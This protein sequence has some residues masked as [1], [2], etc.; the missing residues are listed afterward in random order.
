MRALERVLHLPGVNHIGAQTLAVDGELEVPADDKIAKRVDLAVNIQ[1]AGS[2]AALKRETSERR[3]EF[4]AEATRPMWT[5]IAAQN[6]N[7]CLYR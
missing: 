1:P 3:D 7:C 5:T 4:R 6:G 2:E